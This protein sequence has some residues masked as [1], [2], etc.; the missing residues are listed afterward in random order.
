VQEGP[1]SPDVHP[2]PKLIQQPTDATPALRADAA[3]N[4]QRILETATR[5]LADDRG[6]GMADVAAAAG[7]ARATL[8][9]HFPT[10]ADLVAAIRSQAYEDAGAAIAA[11]RL[12]EGS[13][14][15]A[16]RRLI[17]GLVAVGDRYRFL[18]AETRPGEAADQAFKQRENELGQPVL[19]LI[20]RGQQSGELTADVSPIWVNRTLDGL[21]RGA[22]RM[23]AEEQITAR[24]AADLIYRTT[25]RGIA[26]PRLPD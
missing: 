3:R 20:R 17:E 1:S 22:M 24:D 16:L 14:A 12:E 5:V 15:D 2:V 10:R 9:R 18:Q 21:I 19:A 26:G 8:Y 13:A 11:C 25:L 23:V 4:V 6:A 7:L